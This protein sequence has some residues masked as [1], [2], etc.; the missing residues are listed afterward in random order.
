MFFLR[1]YITYFLNMIHKYI[2][3]EK[4][5][6]MYKLNIEIKCINELVTMLT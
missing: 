3:G 5:I 2:L 4:E 6:N 1:G